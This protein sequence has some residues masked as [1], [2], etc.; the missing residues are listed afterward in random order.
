MNIVGGNNYSELVKNDG[1][2]WSIGYNY[3]GQLGTGNAGNRADLATLET[4][5]QSYMTIPTR[6]VTLK[7]SNPVYQITPSNSYGFNL[8]YQN[9]I[10]GEYS[11]ES[12]DINVADVNGVTGKVT[13]K[14]LGKTYII[15]KFF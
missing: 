15:I 4:I 14:G 9:N 7:L 10:I 1:T 2:V 6:D 12:L 3:Y 11:Y 13:A 8:L 5:S